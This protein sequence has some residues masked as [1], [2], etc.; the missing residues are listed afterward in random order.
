[1]S[2]DGG[3]LDLSS[4][5]IE[6]TM[7][8]APG[9]TIDGFG[10]LNGP[11]T[12]NG[13]ITAS[14]GDLYVGNPMTGAGASTIG[15]SATLELGGGD[16]QSVAFA[17][18]SAT[19]KLDKPASFVGV[20]NS[21]VAGDVVDL[22]G[23]AP[24][25]V[26]A[27]VQGSN[28]A[29]SSDGTIAYT[30]ALG[31][32]YQG[33]TFLISSDGAGGTDL[34][35]AIAPEDHWIGG[36][37]NWGS[38]SDWSL[39][40]PTSTIA[41]VI[42]PEFA[43]TVTIAA[44]PA[45]AAALTVDAGNAIAVIA[46]HGRASLDVG[47]TLDLQTASGLQISGYPGRPSWQAEIIAG[48]VSIDGGSFLDQ[49]AGD[50][51]ISSATF[52]NNG[53][54][55]FSSGYHGASVTIDAD[56]L[57]TGTLAFGGLENLGGPGSGI[58]P[59][60]GTLEFTGSVANTIS[61]LSNNALL[62]LDDPAGFS[63]SLQG[64]ITGDVI[65]LPNVS[66]TGTTASLQSDDL[67][68]EQN[69]APA[70]SFALASTF[71]G[72]AFKVGALSGGGCAISVLQMEIAGGHSRR[73]IKAMPRAGDIP[74]PVRQPGVCLHRANRRIMQ[75][76]PQRRRPVSRPSWPPIPRTRPVPLH[77]G[78]P[79]GHRNRGRFKIRVYAA[80]RVMPSAPNDCGSRA[81]ICGALRVAA[82]A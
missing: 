54:Y 64:F 59:P 56:V 31:S 79:P 66:P 49:V 35:A 62:R 18:A 37:G 33:E 17:A 63:G 77:V 48:A 60:A 22:S 30:F 21:I 75:R 47:G 58:A 19:L 68:I 2:I 11:L 27:S 44:A 51:T 24:A 6:S 25:G 82:S 67:V 71:S 15:S 5:T 52:T 32:T 57:G 20:M 3:I 50:V 53:T 69:G 10:N 72:E 12:N 65:A 16:S 61:F 28:L 73:A 1:M 41:A 34:T 74:P 46:E 8:I 7:S 70:Y 80:I 26:S 39:G 13:I 42:D 9:A 76:L 23:I 4:G 55:A 45:T 38:A 78:R 40:V 36:S 29:V 43:A 14:G 81:Q